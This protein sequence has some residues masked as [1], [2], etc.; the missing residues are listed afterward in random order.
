MIFK[1]NSL[2]KFSHRSAINM[3]NEKI[4]RN[5]NYETSKFRVTKVLNSTRYNSIQKWVSGKNQEQKSNQILT[6]NNISHFHRTYFP[7]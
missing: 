3:I 6:L 7:N 1:L 5:F 4:T 2:S